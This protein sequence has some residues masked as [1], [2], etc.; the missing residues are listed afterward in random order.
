MKNTMIAAAIIA[1]SITVS[2]ATDFDNEISW[3]EQNTRYAETIAETSG[4]DYPQVITIA[5]DELVDMYGG[6][7]TRGLYDRSKNVIYIADSISGVDLTGLII[8]E[9]VHF[10]QHESGNYFAC[11]GAMEKEAY[12]AQFEYAD[13]M[14]SPYDADPVKMLLIT[15]CGGAS[16]Y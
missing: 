13:Q 2:H 3:I 7:D 14:G 16:W 12:A 6:E 11:P 1:A 15:Q 8:H 10:F 9:F 5:T 4:E